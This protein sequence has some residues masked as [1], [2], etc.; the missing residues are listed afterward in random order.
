MNKSRN[1]YLLSLKALT[2]FRYKLFNDDIPA[3]FENLTCEFFILM[4][5]ALRN[6]CQGQVKRISNAEVTNERL[7]EKVMEVD[8]SR[9]WGSIYDTYSDCLE[10]PDSK[11]EF[12]PAYTKE[13]LDSISSLQL[14]SDVKERY[15]IIIQNFEANLI[16]SR[17]ITEQIEAAKRSIN[18]IAQ[19]ISTDLSEFLNDF[20][21]MNGSTGTLQN[22]QCGGSTPNGG[23]NGAPQNGLS[24][25]EPCDTSL[26]QSLV[27]IRSQYNCVVTKYK[28]LFNYSNKAARLKARK[29]LIE[30]T[31][32]GALE[33]SPSTYKVVSVKRQESVRITKYVPRPVAAVNVKL[34]GGDVEQYCKA[35]QKD[36]PPIVLS[37]IEFI[38]EHGMFDQGIFRVS[39]AKS[40]VRYLKDYFEGGD[41]PLLSPSADSS[42]EDY[43][44][45][46]V[47]ELLK[48]YFRE[49][50]HP[51]LPNEILK[52]FIDLRKSQD[53]SPSEELPSSSEN[54]AVCVEA[55]KNILSNMP[56]STM[57]TLRYLFAFLHSLTRFSDENMMDS[58]NLAIVWG[59]TLVRPEEEDQVIMQTPITL[60]VQFLI[61]NHSQV[62]PQDSGSLF[63]DTTTRSRPRTLS[64]ADQGSTCSLADTSTEVSSPFS[65]NNNDTSFDANLSS[66]ASDK[67]AQLTFT[68]IRV[69]SRSVP[70]TPSSDSSESTYSPASSP[71]VPQR[72]NK[73]KRMA[74]LLISQPAETVK[75]ASVVPN[76]MIP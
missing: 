48:R 58:Y 55:L 18:N 46:A 36:I 35:I 49:L 57:V 68:P 40:T 10:V 12:L 67:S 50:Q 64:L 74:P 15:P 34:F 52:D 7:E 61:V 24:R 25:K 43:E 44:V 6:L 37:C 2:H 27:K 45:G 41:D 47:A 22:S 42:A 69:N 19:N 28:D 33:T 65:Q 9:E 56:Y 3:L 26:K 66:L 4:K 1:D 39:G 11:L 72:S 71:K 13:W 5:V 29:D 60:L 32:G 23:E 75:E 70:A 21:N 76:K 30:S 38:R 62:F 17:E 73:Q 51:A 63:S 53:S 59:P 8:F 14:D 31:F 20:E 54:D 16:K